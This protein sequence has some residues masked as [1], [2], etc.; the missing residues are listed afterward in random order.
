MV[1]YT[2]CVTDHQPPIQ[3]EEINDTRRDF[4]DKIEFVQ[5]LATHTVI[6]RFCLTI[7]GLR[8]KWPSTGRELIVRISDEKITPRPQLMQASYTHVI[9]RLFRDSST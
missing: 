3:R 9:H 8:A 2:Q 5:S 7:E 1:R 6:C 4:S